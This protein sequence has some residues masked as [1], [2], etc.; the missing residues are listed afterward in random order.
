ML[1]A[2]LD[3]DGDCEVSL[4]EWISYLVEKKMIKGE[5]KFGHLLRYSQRTIKQS[6]EAFLRTELEAAQSREKSLSA[7]VARLEAELR[8]AELRLRHPS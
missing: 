5:R 8:E 6:E 3:V 2:I 7:Q 4:M 1:F